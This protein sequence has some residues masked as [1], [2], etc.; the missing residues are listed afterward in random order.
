MLGITHELLL[1]LCN[2]NSANFITYIIDCGAVYIEFIRQTRLKR[3]NN[4]CKR[5]KKQILAD[6]I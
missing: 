2:T 3:V 6:Y 1:V 5:E 4:F